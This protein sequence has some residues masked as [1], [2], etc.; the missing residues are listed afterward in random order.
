MFGI[1]LYIIIVFLE[2]TDNSPLFNESSL[3]VFQIF[4]AFILLKYIKIEIVSIVIGC[5]VYSILQTAVTY[6]SVILIEYPASSFSGY[7]SEGFSYTFFT[8]LIVG[9]MFFLH[10]FMD[11]NLS[12]K[13]SSNISIGDTWDLE[14]ISAIDC[15]LLNEIDKEISIYRINSILTLGVILLVMIAAGLFT[16]FAGKI[17]TEDDILSSRYSETV[18][19]QISIEN[20]VDDLNGLLLSISTISKNE[21]SSNYLSIDLKSFKVFN[22][23]P[24]QIDKSKSTDIDRDPRD[25][26]I[27]QA[28]AQILHEYLID[29]KGQLANEKSELLLEIKSLTGLILDSK[30]A[31]NI[32]KILLTTTVTR[33]GFAVLAL[34][35]VSIL[36]SLYRYNAKVIYVLNSIRNSIVLMVSHDLKLSETMATLNVP[37][38]F[39]IDKNNIYSLWLDKI[40]SMYST[41]KKEPKE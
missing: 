1:F 7:L 6:Y 37:I 38:D 16:V 27:D 36:V 32:A 26:I 25:F 12:T 20:E 15:S 28:N 14:K 13:N 29:Y 30:N 39:K 23:L 5:F 41:V 22:V 31:D 10:R 40:N 24:I 2:L 8:T 34:F 11:L 35:L 4:A 9:I 17:I 19:R 3:V 33:F 21:G 18:A